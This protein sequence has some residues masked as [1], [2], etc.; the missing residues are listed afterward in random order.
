MSHFVYPTIDY[1][2]SDGKYKFQIFKICV[3]SIMVK[4][5]NLY[6]CLLDFYIFFSQNYLFRTVVHFYI[7]LLMICRSAFPVTDAKQF[8]TL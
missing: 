4:I 5:K 8:T 6:S 1:H 7:G 2:Q 3:I